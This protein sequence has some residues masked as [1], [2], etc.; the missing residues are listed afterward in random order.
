MNKI[1]EFSRDTE[2]FANSKAKNTGI[3]LVSRN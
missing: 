1:G 3:K 2:R